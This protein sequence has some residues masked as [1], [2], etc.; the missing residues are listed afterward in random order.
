M[1]LVWGIFITLLGLIGWGGQVITMLSPKLAV[2]L[3]VAEPESEVDPVF[4]TDFRAEATWDSCIQWNL[5]VAGILLTINNPYWVYLGLF[6]GSTYLY[7][8]G[9]NIIQRIFMSH[10]NIKIGTP[11]NI[12]I[13]YIFCSLWGISGLITL[14]FA[15]NVLITK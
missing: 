7:I 4:A 15:L 12:K 11:T 13:A 8:S 14:I 1:Y 9:R 10:R 6:G 5:L 3:G 2:K